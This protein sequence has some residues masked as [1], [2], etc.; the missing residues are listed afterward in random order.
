MNLII[1]K[2]FTRISEIHSDIETWLTDIKEI[3]IILK[4][5]DILYYDVKRNFG[6]YEI[7][8]YAKLLRLNLR[9]LFQD[10]IMQRMNIVAHSR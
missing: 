9:L 1:K 3:D 8:Y 5:E 4:N 2:D 6:S 7:D 10:V